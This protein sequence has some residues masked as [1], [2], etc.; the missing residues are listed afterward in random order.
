MIAIVCCVLAL[1]RE[2]GEKIPVRR[3]VGSPWFVFVEDSGAWRK[4]QVEGK[5]LPIE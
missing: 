2:G 5:D 3:I 1:I 4:L